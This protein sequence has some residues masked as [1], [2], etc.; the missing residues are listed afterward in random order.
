MSAYDN[1]QAAEQVDQNPSVMP[2]ENIA[3]IGRVIVEQVVDSNRTYQREA[4]RR[5]KEKFAEMGIRNKHDLK[6]AVAENT[7]TEDLQFGN[8]TVLYTTAVASFVEKALRDPLFARQVT[9]SLTLQP[10][11][12][13]TKVPKGTNKSAAQTVNNDG[14][15]NQDSNDYGSSTVQ[16]DLYGT[17]DTVTLELL[18]STQIDVIA[19]QL[20]EIGR[21]INLKMDDLILTEL[22]DATDPTGSYGD[23]SNYNYLGSGD[24]DISYDNLVNAIHSAK[25][26]SMEPTHILASPD[27]MGNLETNSDFKT[28]AAY[29]STTGQTGEIVQPTMTFRGLPVLESGNVDSDRL[30]IVD[31]NRLGYFIDGGPVQTFDLQVNNKAAF[32]VMGVKRFGVQ[33]ARPK[34]VYKVEEAADTPT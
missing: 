18:Q 2:Q 13:S 31:A 24:S 3:R 23:N 1:V 25:G 4:L 8:N 7:R 28:A 32:E 5:M 30:Y 21:S 15:V 17:R 33:L 6:R 20:E 19:D 22:N 12:D 29:T 16:T 14:T 27:V 26:N 9:K 34:A 11:S 10:G